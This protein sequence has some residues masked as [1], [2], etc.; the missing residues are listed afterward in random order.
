MEPFNPESVNRYY[1]IY[2]MMKKVFC[3]LLFV[4]VADSHS[5]LILDSSIENVIA[6]FMNQQY[7]KARTD[8][9]SILK[10]KPDNIDALFMH[11]NAGQIEIIDYES[12]VIDGYRYLKFVDSSLATFESKLQS[13]SHAEKARCLFYTGTVYGMKSLVLA[14]L[15]EWLKAIKFSRMYVNHLKQA[16]E[17]DSTMI[18]PLYGIGLVNY[19]L[20]EN[21]KWLPF[22]NKKARRG[23][24]DIEKVAQSSSPLNFMA[25]N[26]LAWIY[27]ERKEY[28]KADRVVSSVLSDYPNNTMF[29]RIKARI[30]LYDKKYSSA[31]ALSK[32]LITLSQ[33]RKP[34][35]WHDLINGY[36]ITVA[37][38]DAAGKYKDCLQVAEKALG[39]EVP[40]S[41]KKIE[42]VKKHLDYIAIKKKNL[43]EKL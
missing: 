6:R 18:E 14:K 30:A 20:G 41:T 1:I 42:Y 35:N 5:T 28:K 25:K 9:A 17:I 40:V 39:I 19:Y 10:E 37:S 21:F 8:I 24:Q 32:K 26:S 36:Q 34:I 3:I 4:I 11:L 15:G 2:L 33:E 7:V 16:R 31:I 22:M 13:C 38:L 12:Y 23:L 43:E 27:V 29:L